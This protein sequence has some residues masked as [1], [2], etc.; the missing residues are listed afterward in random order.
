MENELFLAKLLSQRG[1]FDQKS[2]LWVYWNQKLHLSL[3]SD[4]LR[5]AL[6]VFLAKSYTMSW[7]KI[8]EWLIKLFQK[9][10]PLREGDLCLDLHTP[11]V[12][13]IKNFLNKQGK[14]QT[15]QE[16][17]LESW[18]SLLLQIIE[19]IHGI[20]GEVKKGNLQALDQKEEQHL[21]R[22]YQDLSLP[23]YASEEE[24]RKSFNSLAKKSHPDTFGPSELDEK[25]QEKVNA[26]F[27]H[28]K[29]QYDFLR[30]FAKKR[31][32]PLSQLKAMKIN[33]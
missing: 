3:E 9:K 13:L 2:P 6:E 33:A 24:L 27:A 5:I 17:Y 1:N 23:L 21:L 19:V 31:K 16:K 15:T 12:A 26:Q 29:S 11:R 30:E 8:L 10:G 7:E 32:G 14:L 18:E 25:K 28:L 4:D 22:A 20:Q